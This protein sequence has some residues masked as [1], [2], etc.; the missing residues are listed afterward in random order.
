MLPDDRADLVSRLQQRG[1]RV[2]VVGDGVGD[3]DALASADVGIAIGSDQLA[4]ADIVLGSDDPRAVA[5][6]LDLSR[7]MRRARARTLGVVAAYHAIAI[8]LAAGAFAGLG[9]LLPLELAAAL[10]ILLVGAVVA[11]VRWSSLPRPAMMVP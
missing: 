11:T 7:A 5:D 4:A 2:A 10:P 3:A 9:V 1:A 8:P 6:V